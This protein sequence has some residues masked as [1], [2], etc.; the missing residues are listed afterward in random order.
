MEFQTTCIIYPSTE[1]DSCSFLATFLLTSKFLG[2]GDYS[3][4]CD[5]IDLD[6]CWRYASNK[7]MSNVP[8][9]INLAEI[10][11]EEED[12]QAPSNAM[13]ALSLYINLV[14]LITQT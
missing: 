9:F 4:E 1:V 2:L 13:E 8:E 6:V 11:M 5:S 7:P 3:S 10:L 12:L 14:N